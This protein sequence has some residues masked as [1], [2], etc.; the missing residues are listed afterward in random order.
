MPYTYLSEQ[1]MADRITSFP[2]WLEQAGEV[3]PDQTEGVTVADLAELYPDIFRYGPYYNQWQAA[4]VKLDKI[5]SSDEAD[6]L[7]TDIVFLTVAWS[8]IVENEA[9]FDSHRQS[10]IREDMDHGSGSPSFNMIARHPGT[11][12][13]YEELFNNETFYKFTLGHSWNRLFIDYT[14]MVMGQD[15]LAELPLYKD[16][17][18]QL[19][20]FQAKWQLFEQA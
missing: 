2:S 14:M 6:A 11:N 17:Y 13:L 20:D 4:C 3:S 12:E 1:Q 10:R 9:T 18:Q 19:M 5:L 15:V 16:T 7:I 8:Y